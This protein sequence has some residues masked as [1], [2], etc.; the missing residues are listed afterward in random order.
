MVSR[1]SCL[2]PYGSLVVLQG[3][4]RKDELTN[5]SIDNG[6]R[7]SISELKQPPRIQPELARW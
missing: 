3:T 1:V 4:D 5:T 7:L 2:E 6:G